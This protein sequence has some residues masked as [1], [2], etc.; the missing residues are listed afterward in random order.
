M[1]LHSGS[2]RMTV[3]ARAR[4]IDRPRLP[5]GCGWVTD[6]ADTDIPQLR[7]SHMHMAAL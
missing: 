2:R 6:V 7:R 5:V 1:I 4:G 3:Y